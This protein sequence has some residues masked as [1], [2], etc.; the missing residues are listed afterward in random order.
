MRYEILHKEKGLSFGYDHACGEFLQ[1]WTRPVDLK[2]RMNQDK[3]G[4]DP[5]EMLIDEDT[6]FTRLTREKMMQLV[7]EHGFT[8]EE[9][10]ERSSNTYKDVLYESR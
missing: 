10:M 4:P 3:Y 7:Q 9:L 1:I 8:I 6:K 2:E 5:E